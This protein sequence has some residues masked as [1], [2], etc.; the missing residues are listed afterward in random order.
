L[1]PCFAVSASPPETEVAGS[2]GNGAGE[3]RCS[4]GVAK[5]ATSVNPVAV[6]KPR[7]AKVVLRILEIK[8]PPMKF[9]I[10]WAE[11]SLIGKLERTSSFI[12]PRDLGRSD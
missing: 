9:G 1:E 11:K 3:S 6:I 12:D 5:S 2:P 8:L 10:R 7:S 4:C